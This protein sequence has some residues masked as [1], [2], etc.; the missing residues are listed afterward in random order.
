M[1]WGGGGGGHTLCMY[2]LLQHLPFVVMSLGG[3][4]SFRHLFLDCNPPFSKLAYG[5]E[6]SPPG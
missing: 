1:L 5:S 3:K 2:G 6:K 4:V